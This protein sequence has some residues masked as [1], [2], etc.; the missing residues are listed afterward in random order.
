[1]LEFMKK[2]I[3]RLIGLYLNALAIVAP[4]RAGHR[5]FMLFCR[6]FRTAI[7]GKQKSF[8]DSATSFFLDANGVVIQGYKWGAGE[9]KVL[10]L[11]GWQS[12]S[13]RWKTYVDALSKT[14]YTIY[15]LDAPGHGLSKGDFLTVP[16][17]SSLIQQFILDAGNLHAV[18][19]HSLGSFSLLYTF[20]KYPLLPVKKVI[21]MAP[22]GEAKD[23]VDVFRT[24]LGV[25]QNVIRQIE[26]RF[27]DLYDVKPD[28]FS[29]VKFGSS[30]RIPGLIIHDVEDQEAPYHYS[31][32]LHQAWRRSKLIT[33]KGF[34][35]NLKS[36]SVVQQVVNFID[37]NE[38][39]NAVH[40]NEQISGSELV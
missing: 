7:T 10:F 37:G 11:H 33:H 32:L 18:V 19:G 3:V 8:F 34:G 5:A 38:V 29:S 25:S 35:H 22:P 31:T 12:H 24:T 28:Y 40:A 9:K 30:L 27:V 1:M 4:R 13:Y 21:A 23:F 14:E 2:L 36:P 16:I 26:E 15:A 39:E 20:Y 17:Y 6:P